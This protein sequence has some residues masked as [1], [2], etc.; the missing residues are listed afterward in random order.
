M[1]SNKIDHLFKLTH[2]WRNKILDDWEKK[3][4]EM[5]VDEMVDGEMAR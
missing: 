4:R 1:S 2:T 3:V 5:M